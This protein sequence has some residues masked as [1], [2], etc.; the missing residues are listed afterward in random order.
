MFSEGKPIDPN[1]P[2]H[3]QKVQDGS[4][5]RIHYRLRGGAPGQG[6]QA[7]FSF[8]EGKCSYGTRCIFSRTT[9]KIC[10][11][12]C[13][14]ENHVPEECIHYGRG[15]Y[16]PRL[17]PNALKEAER[18]AARNRTPPSS[19]RPTEPLH[20]PPKSLLKKYL[21]W[22]SWT[23]KQS[24]IWHGTD[25]EEQY[26]WVE[27]EPVHARRAKPPSHPPVKRTGARLRPRM[28]SSGKRSPTPPR[29]KR[30]RL[31][32]SSGARQ[33]PLL[34]A[35]PRKREPKRRK[36]PEAVSAETVGT[37]PKAEGRRLIPSGTQHAICHSPKK[38]QG[39]Q[40]LDLIQKVRTVLSQEG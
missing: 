30:A 33:P 39:C 27:E 36:E 29:S 37:N 6:R 20:P 34:A 40:N 38:T 3:V 35:P 15:S 13:G 28:N 16:D 32:T 12:V 26:E 19:L 10:C 23:S 5:V 25:Y 7:C 2:L 17:D 21:P 24:A 22:S 8:S 11:D 18:A 14:S 9:T 1:I 4:Y 31:A